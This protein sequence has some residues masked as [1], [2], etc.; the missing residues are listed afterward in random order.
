MASS[1]ARNLPHVKVGLGSPK[2]V[3]FVYPYYENAAFLLKQA[4]TWREYPPEL[5]PFLSIIIVDDGSRIPCRCPSLI[6]FRIRLF[7]VNIDVRWNWLAARNIGAHHAE[8]EWI[9]L[10]DMDHIVPAETARALV[11]GAHNA[12]VIYA[13][14]RREHT[15]PLIQPH[16]ASFLLS[17]EVFWTIGGYDESLSGYY[18][19]DGDF[20]RRAI[21]W[22]SIRVLP[23]V[24]VRHER[25]GDSS[26]V[27]YLRKQPIDQT[28][29]KIMAARPATGWHPKTLS[30]PYEEVRCSAS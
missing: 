22:A 24:L 20:R 26:T 10:T 11:F 16:S 15:G 2:A 13:L 12:A 29:Q 19:T 5:W 30:F 7:R 3:T 14:S 8:S 6:P 25:V 28:A 27:R 23:D 1:W 9:L 21:V 17:R 4:Q 18:G